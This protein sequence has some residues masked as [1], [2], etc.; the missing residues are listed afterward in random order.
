MSNEER[1]QYFQRHG[2]MRICCRSRYLTAVDT[3]EISLRSEEARRTLDRD[4]T[5][6]KIRY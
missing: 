3:H 2:I 6:A 5:V 4:G 1:L